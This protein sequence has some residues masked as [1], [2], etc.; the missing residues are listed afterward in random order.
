MSNNYWDH[1]T[2]LKLYSLQRRRE[3]YTILHVWKILEGHVP[4]ISGEGHGG[5]SKLHSETHRNGRLCKIPALSRNCPANIRQ[6]REGSLTYHG[7]QLFNALP[8]D[9]RNTSNCNIDIFK[10]KVDSFLQKVADKPLVRGYT[11][12]CLTESNSLTHM[13]P[14][15]TRS[16]SLSDTPPT[17]RSFLG[18]FWRWY[19]LK[20]QKSKVK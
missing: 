3:R 17:T 9:V 6:L 14:H 10:R 20:P 12:G 7:P 15:H 5:I 11:S 2:H 1:L 18:L 16:G 4:N 8:K 13:I 19:C